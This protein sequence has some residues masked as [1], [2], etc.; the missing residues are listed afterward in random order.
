[1]TLTHEQGSHPSLVNQDA[2]RPS[3]RRSHGEDD[4][5]NEGP[6]GHQAV[7]AEVH[8]PAYSSALKEYISHSVIGQG[9]MNVTIYPCLITDYL[10]LFKKNTILRMEK[11]QC[12]WPAVITVLHTNCQFQ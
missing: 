1:M 6:R 12:K 4:G 8:I 5:A 11:L 10:I 7:Q 3:P 9:G 2:Q